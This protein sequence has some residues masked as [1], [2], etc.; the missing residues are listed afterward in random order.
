VSL[1]QFIPLLQWSMLLYFQ[2]SGRSGQGTQEESS[3]LEDVGDI[4]LQNV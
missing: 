4:I 3:T 1:G 2:G